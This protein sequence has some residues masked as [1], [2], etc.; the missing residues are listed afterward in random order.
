MVQ[1]KIKITNSIF[2][3][4]ECVGKLRFLNIVEKRHQNAIV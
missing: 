4:R 2:F 3:M 1:N